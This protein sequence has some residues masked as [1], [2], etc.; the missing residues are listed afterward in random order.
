[1]QDDLPTEGDRDVTPRL[2]HLADLRE[3]RVASGDPDI[4]GWRVRTAS[5]EKIGSVK[6]LI[7]DTLLMKVRYIE[8]R[9]DREVL[10]AS[11]DRLVLVPVAQAELDDRDDE[12]TLDAA[13]VDPRT[14]PPY[15]REALARE[16]EP[17]E[18]R[19]HPAHPAPVSDEA[20][21]FGQRR[22]G[23]EGSSYLTLLDDTPRRTNE[24]P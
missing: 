23:R 8:V 1:M 14:L 16:V 21:F 6:D 9:I 7:V 17:L 5:G 24:L 18:H 3:L 2:M 11:D 15:D 19:A 13:I 22:R 20:R 4:R 10:N 12:V